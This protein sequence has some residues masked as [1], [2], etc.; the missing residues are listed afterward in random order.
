[1]TTAEAAPHERGWRRLLPA[2]AVFLFVPAVPQLRVLVPVEQT[3]V[4][5]APALAVG[6]W[7]GWRRGG[8]LW[9]ALLGTVLAGWIL[10]RPM[11]GSTS[12]VAFAR[13][14][15]LLLAGA[16]G[17]TAVL[18][19]VRAF[20]PRA[21]GAIG[22][23]GVAL[24]AALLAAGTGPQRLGAVL[25]AELADRVDL[26]VAVLRERTTTPEWATLEQDNPEG[27]AAVRELVDGVDA[28]LRALAPVGAQLFPAFL[29]LEAL[30]ALG[31][32]WSLFHRVSRI[33]LGPPLARVRD[34]RFDDQLV[35]GVVVGLVFVLLPRLAEAKVVGMNLLVFF[36]ALYALRGLGVMSWFLVS[37]G[38]I[39]GPLLMVLIAMVP[40]LWSIPLGLGL[41]DTWIDWRRRARP[42]NPGSTQ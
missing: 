16:F 14:W 15:A 9:L 2:L 17:A 26:S 35:W 24:L 21:L 18:G 12:Y 28:Q 31:L 7:V 20:L 22:L 37:P 34:F 19:G 5:L 40:V 25:E 4:L 13:G 41:G 32:A 3:L 33:R 6:A 42:S 27:A 11:P 29:A 30:C 38:R 36:G 1:V 23:A 8:A 10:A 39:G